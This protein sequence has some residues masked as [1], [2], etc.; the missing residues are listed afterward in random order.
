VKEKHACYFLKKD[1]YSPWC[2]QCSMN[3]RDHIISELKDAG[4]LERIALIFTILYPIAKEF[5]GYVPI[6]NIYSILDIALYAV[7]ITAI[8]LNRKVRKE[9]DIFKN[10]SADLFDLCRKLTDQLGKN[11]KEKQIERLHKQG[12]ETLIP[13]QAHMALDISTPED[14]L[15]NEAAEA[16]KKYD[17]NK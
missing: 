6:Y 7:L 13:L 11:N 9:R 1:L 3:W 2:K 12:T 10:K 8:I 14:I 5:G 15:F 17:K 16:L 4:I